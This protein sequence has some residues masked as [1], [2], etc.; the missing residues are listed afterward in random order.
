MKKI[1]ALVLAGGTLPED[2]Q[3]HSA[4]YDNR[5]LLKLGDKFMIEYVIDAL[6]GCKGVGKILVVGLKEPLQKVLGDRADDVME[7]RD[8]M[9]EN[10]RIGA[11][12]FKDSPALLIVTCDIPLIDSG[13]IDR[14]M[15]SCNA[16]KADVYYPIVEKKFNDQKYPE[17]R[18]TYF[19]LRDG[20]YTGGNVVMLDPGV[21][22]ENWHLLEKAIAARKSPLKLLSMIGIGFIFAYLT[23]RLTTAALEEKIRRI[24]GLK[25]K[26]VKVVDPEIGIDVDK[27]SDYLLVEKRLKSS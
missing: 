20:V 7:A 16:E 27:E 6:R 10:I 24:T 9:L 15:E 13:M 22:R 12:R 25:G 1:D 18:R 26:A 17:T 23:G 19:R 5:A 2:L 3:K 14:F 21:F 8:S 4:G 11:D